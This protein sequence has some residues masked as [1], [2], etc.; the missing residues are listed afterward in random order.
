M[1]ILL[2]GFSRGS[3]YA[4]IAV[5]FA[6]VF[7]AARILNLAHASFFMLGAYATYLFHHLLFSSLSPSFGVVLSVVLATTSVGLL[8]LLFFHTVLKPAPHSPDLVMVLCLATNVFLAELL[9]LVAGA[10]STMVPPIL[11]GHL[12]VGTTPILRQEMLV[13]PVALIVFAAL[14]ILLNRT[15]NGRAIRALGQ[16]PTAAVLSG[17]DPDLL[18]AMVVSMSAALAALAGGLVSPIRVLSPVMWL[19]ALVKSFAIV[20]LGG[21]GSLRGALAASFLLGFLEVATIRLWSD[22]ASEAVSL[23]VIAGVLVL[24]PRG[25]S[26]LWRRDAAWR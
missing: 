13:I 3:L 11:D 25:L 2:Q 22:A 19:P 1:E 26:S 15:R 9:R 23:A 7:G 16:N 10:R 12:L 8:G 14:G 20:I 4:L 17:V 24:R 21:I 18:S 5:G 6:A